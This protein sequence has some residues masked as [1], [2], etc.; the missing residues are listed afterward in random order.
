VR[1]ERPPCDSRRPR[2]RWSELRWCSRPT[3]QEGCKARS[4]C[5]ARC[6]EP[7]W[8]SRSRGRPSPTASDDIA[9]S[10]CPLEQNPLSE[11]FVRTLQH[12]C[13]VNIHERGSYAHNRET[14]SADGI[15]L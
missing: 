13:T 12:R 7:K 4:C 10:Y 8:W 2:R 3:A 1:P 11:M 9:T 15:S 6:S 14:P 5:S